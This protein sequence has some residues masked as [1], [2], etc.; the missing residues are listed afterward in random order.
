MAPKQAVWTVSWANPLC[1][2]DLMNKNISVMLH[3]RMITFL[4]HT[5]EHFRV[6]DM[7]VLAFT[8]VIVCSVHAALWIGLTP[9]YNLT[10]SHFQSKSSKADHIM[11]KTLCGFM[12]KL[13]REPWSICVCV[14]SIRVHDGR[15]WPDS[16][17]RFIALQSCLSSHCC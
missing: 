2:D 17:D 15:K 4:R 10:L 3:L 13:C 9:F 14:W 16:S 12:Y 8:C 11:W 7:S 6:C 5:C 1:W